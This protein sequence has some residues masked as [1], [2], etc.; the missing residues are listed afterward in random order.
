VLNAKVFVYSYQIMCEFGDGLMIPLLDCRSKDQIVNWG[1]Q[2]TEALQKHG[3]SRVGRGSIAEESV[4]RHFVCIVSEAH[5]LLERNE[6]SF[7][8]D[9]YS[10]REIK[11]MSR[12]ILAASK[13]RD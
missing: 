11:E 12:K 9:I 13:K 5:A 8:N 10:E 3:I 4:V 1:I 6:G 2:L 7:R